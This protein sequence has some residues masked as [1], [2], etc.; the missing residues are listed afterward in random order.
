MNNDELDFVN[1]ILNGNE[2]YL[3]SEE[4]NYKTLEEIDEKREEALYY[5]YENYLE[6]DNNKYNLQLYL[7]S[8][9]EY[10]YI[11]NYEDINYGDYIRYPILDD[12]TDI[13]MHTGG[14]IAKINATNK[15]GEVLTHLFLLKGPRAQDVGPFKK[16]LYWNIQK[17]TIIFRKLTQDDKLKASVAELLSELFD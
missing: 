1:N 6:H 4:T 16:T 10:E 8:M 5:I 15:F 17:D 3:E 11:E 13:K 14:Y 7:D 2:S 12:L 9:A